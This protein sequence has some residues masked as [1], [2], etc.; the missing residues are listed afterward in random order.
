MQTISVRAGAGAPILARRLALIVWIAIATITCG[1]A[2]LIALPRH[3]GIYPVYAEAGQK[4]RAGHDLYADKDGFV[5]F[6][7][8]PL[9][10]A[11]LVPFGALPDVAGAFGW[12]LL[13][14]GLYV[15]GLAYWLRSGLPR[16][17]SARQEALFYL[18][19]APLSIYGLIN[20]QANGLVIGLLLLTAATVVQG[21]WNWAAAFMALACLLKIYPIA[22]GLLLAVAYPRAFAGRLAVALAG[23][24]ALPFLLQQ[25]GYVWLQYEG[26]GQLLISDNGRQDWWCLDLWYRDVRFLCKIWWEPLAPRT[27]QFLQVGAAA[28]LAGLCLAGRW[29]GWSRAR[30][31]TSALGLSCCWMLVLGPC[32]EGCTYILLAPALVWAIVETNSSARSY[33][34]RALLLL[35]YAAL[36]SVFVA[37]LFPWNRAFQNLAPHPFAGVVLF[38]ALLGET[39]RQLVRPSDLRGAG[40]N[41]D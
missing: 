18:L 8:S 34:Y 15:V 32:T 24:L 26:W 10:A 41:G 2:L 29:A 6:R 39:L 31:T 21:R 36:L 17:L 16:P 13:N 11:L 28:A 23:G 37:T 22:F 20:G 33:L 30:L 40:Y 9:I 27:Y 3:T 4:W 12:R 14:L 19:L 7:Y 5:I 25:P 35:S 1:R 38:A